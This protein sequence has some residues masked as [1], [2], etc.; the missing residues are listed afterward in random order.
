MHV[1]S[2]GDDRART[3]S[4]TDSLY[5]AIAVRIFAARPDSSPSPIQFDFSNSL[6][7]DMS[8]ADGQTAHAID[9]L[10]ILVQMGYDCCIRFAQPGKER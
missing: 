3:S 1:E 4:S 8:L 6:C 7:K 10:E 5:L 9:A 2:R